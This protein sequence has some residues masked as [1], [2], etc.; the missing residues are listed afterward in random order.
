MDLCNNIGFVLACLLSGSTDVTVSPSSSNPGSLSCLL[1]V[2]LLVKY[3]YYVQGHFCSPA[4]SVCDNDDM[5]RYVDN[6]FSTDR[7]GIGLNIIYFVF[8]GIFFFLLTLLIE[9]DR[10]S[11]PRLHCS[12]K[13]GGIL[14][15][16]ASHECIIFDLDTTY[17]NVHHI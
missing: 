1:V 5:F 14:C 15:V 16:I 8:E 17:C 7:P 11:V 10:G 12:E 4:C 9:V 13:E 6:V 2:I 3:T